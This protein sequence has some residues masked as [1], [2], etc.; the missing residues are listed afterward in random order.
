MD[1]SI[2][3]RSSGTQ[4]T[5]GLA[6]AKSTLDTPR[7]PPVAACFS[8]L[9]TKRT[10]TL[11]I[12]ASRENRVIDPKANGHSEPEGIVWMQALRD[13]TAVSDPVDTRGHRELCVHRS[14]GSWGSTLRSDGKMAMDPV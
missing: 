11:L 3:L 5:D 12:G 10:A 14:N 4:T 7:L 2:R 6:P 8:T 13:R 1:Q 9:H